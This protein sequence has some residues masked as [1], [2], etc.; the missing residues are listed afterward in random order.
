MF[1]FPLFGTID[2]CAIQPARKEVGYDH[3]ITD[4]VRLTF[5]KKLIRCDP[6]EVSVLK[7]ASL[8]LVKLRESAQ[9]A[10]KLLLTLL[11][12]ELRQ[13]VLEAPLQESSAE[14]A[15]LLLR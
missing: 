15:A 12:L 2:Q 1:G 14:A 4:G 5:L 9:E 10:Q 6:R 11:T 3:Y 13:K 7:P 8:L